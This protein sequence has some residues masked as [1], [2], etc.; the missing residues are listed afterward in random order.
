MQKNN[1]EHICR[2]SEC[3]GACKVIEQMFDL[4]PRAKDKVWSLKH[5]I[6]SLLDTVDKRNNKLNK[7]EVKLDKR[8]NR[9]DK[10]VVDTYQYTKALSE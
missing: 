4:G 9:F 6:A 2:A 1:S 5:C 10:K 3:C 7:N 8:N